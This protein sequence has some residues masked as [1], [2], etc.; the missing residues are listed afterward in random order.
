MPSRVRRRPRSTEPSRHTGDRCGICDS[1]CSCDPDWK[2]IRRR[3][4]DCK[5]LRLAEDRGWTAAPTRMR[6]RLRLGAE[7]LAERGDERLHREAVLWHRGDL[8]AG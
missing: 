3:A 8:E 7:Q 2:T 5:R 6:L 4:A 1:S